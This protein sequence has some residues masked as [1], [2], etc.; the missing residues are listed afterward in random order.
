MRLCGPELA[1]ELLGLM[2]DDKN[3]KGLK[4]K[5]EKLSREQLL[6][7]IETLCGISEAQSML[8]LMV[9]PSKRDID[10]AL[11][12]FSTRCEIYM[13]NSCNIRDYDRMCAALE[14]LYAAYKYADAKMSAYIIYG[15]HSAL[16]DNDILEQEYSDIMADLLWDLETTLKTSPD[17]F[18]EEERQRYLT[19]VQE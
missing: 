7:L 5:L 2:G 14:P 8:K 1:E 13:C 17:V 12:K 10:R 19:I 15:I 3:E 9:S 6:D 16:Y 18:T 11:N 4:E